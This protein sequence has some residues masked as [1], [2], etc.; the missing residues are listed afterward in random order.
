MIANLASYRIHTPYIFV[1]MLSQAE[2]FAD[3]IVGMKKALKRKAYDSD[4]D[5][6]IEQLTNRGNKLR[7]K[8]RFVHE[9]QLAPPSGPSVYKRV[10]NYGFSSE[11]I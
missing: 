4:S 10:R 7:K 8:A 1:T 11:Y 2:I 5:S 3:A 6:S 9:G